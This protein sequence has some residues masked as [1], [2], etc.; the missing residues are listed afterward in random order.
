MKKIEDV[1][2]ALKLFE[3]AAQKRNAA[4]NEGHSKIAN[5]NYDK[6]VNIAKYLRDCKSLHELSIFYTHPDIGVR[7]TAA[8]Y[9]LPVNEKESIKV[10]K[11]IAK[12]N[13]LAAFDAKMTIQEWE[14]GNLRNFY[15][16]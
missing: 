7:K 14:N 15:T 8:T 11:E 16:L 5:R 10:L 13:G 9:L 12:L 2:E 4:I 6:I 3:D 1:Q